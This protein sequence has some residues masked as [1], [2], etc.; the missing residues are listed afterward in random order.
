MDRFDELLAALI[1]AEPDV[2]RQEFAGKHEQ[3]RIDAVEWQTRWGGLVKWA[4]EERDGRTWPEMLAQVM[5]EW[6]E[7]T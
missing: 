4:R 1:E 3:D 6:M 7:R 5:D 2:T